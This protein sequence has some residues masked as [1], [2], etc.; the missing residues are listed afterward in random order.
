MKCDINGSSKGEKQSEM[1]GL[2]FPERANQRRCRLEKARIRTVEWIR[3]VVFDSPKASQPHAKVFLTLVARR[4]HRHEWIEHESLCEA[5]TYNW[6]RV[7]RGR[8]KS[9]RG[10]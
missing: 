2:E 1:P 8:H 7:R 5:P 9:G 4:K 10:T 6:G 3:E